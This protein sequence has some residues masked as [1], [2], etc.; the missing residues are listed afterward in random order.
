MAKRLA[1]IASLATLVVTVVMAQSPPPPPTPTEA[2]QIKQNIGGVKNS[3][4]QSATAIPQIPAT[5]INQPSATPTKTDTTKEGETKSNKSPFNWSNLLTVVFTGV[6]T[7]VGIMQ[8]L[9]MRKQSSY[10]RRQAD[11]MRREL[12]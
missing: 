6:L 12:P 4:T 11:Y 8:W 1:L 7:W 9:S 2:A 3:P 5:V 10:M